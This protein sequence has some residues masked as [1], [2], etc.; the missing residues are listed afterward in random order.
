MPWIVDGAVL[1]YVEEKY[2]SLVDKLW[3]ISQIRPNEEA[4]RWSAQWVG[5]P[6]HGNLAGEAVAVVDQELGVPAT[7]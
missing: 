5:L 3:L 7:S 1:I 4:D 2:C 6:D